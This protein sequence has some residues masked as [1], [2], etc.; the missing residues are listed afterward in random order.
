MNKKTFTLI[1]LVII[2]ATA[3]LQPFN[4]DAGEG[5]RE[6]DPSKEWVRVPEWGAS[7]P[8]SPRITLKWSA[9]IPGLPNL[10]QMNVNG[11]PFDSLP[12]QE[13]AGTSDPYIHVLSADL[14]AYV[15]C[16]KIFKN[17]ESH[18]CR[19]EWRVLRLSNITTTPIR[20]PEFANRLG[21]P[22]FLSS[23]MGYAVRLPNG[24]SGC[25]VYDWDSKRFLTRWDSGSASESMSIQFNRDSASV[26]CRQVIS[27]KPNPNYQGA[28]D[29]RKYPIYGKGFTQ[30]IPRKKNLGLK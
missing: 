29:L 11:R 7:W 10:V 17:G 4:A 5:V 20:P 23:Y 26:T 27:W 14:I 9:G 25:V 13:G 22:T 24:N 19:S 15:G 1:G 16:G 8:I 21:E 12:I 28:E 2:I 18:Q 6:L 30:R 3:L